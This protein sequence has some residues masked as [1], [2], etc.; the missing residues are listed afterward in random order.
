M[1]LLMIVGPTNRQE[2]IRSLI[3]RHDV[4][5]YSELPEV[6]GEGSTGKHLGTPTWPGKS[7]LVFTVVSQEKKDEIVKAIKDYTGSL[8]P[9]EGL[10]AFV[11]DVEEMI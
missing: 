5:T 6:I 10:R 4:H 11:L 1:K 8:Y 2:E 9:G 3:A 7:V